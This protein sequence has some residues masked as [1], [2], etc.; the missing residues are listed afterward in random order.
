M[1]SRGNYQSI[2]YAQQAAQGIQYP[3]RTK[4]I[5]QLYEKRSR[6][7]EHLLHAATKKA[8]DFAVSEGVSR[9][10]IGDIAHI[11]ERKDM[12]RVNNQ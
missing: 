4:R 3:K 2:A 8:V 11:R 10:I 7:V 9:I 1:S 6:Q 5:E 12:G